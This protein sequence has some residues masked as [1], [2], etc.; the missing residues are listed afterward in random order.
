MVLERQE[1]NEVKIIFFPAFGLRAL[2]LT[3]SN[4]GVA[5]LMGGGNLGIWELLRQLEFSVRVLEREMERS[6]SSEICKG[7]PL[8]I[9]S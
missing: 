5:I 4:R 8:N 2:S 7:L 3:K 9:K 6:T 1:I